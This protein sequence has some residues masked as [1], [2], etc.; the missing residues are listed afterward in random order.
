M[1]KLA[2]SLAF[3]GTCA[4]VLGCGKAL[5]RSGN[6]AASQSTASGTP[7]STRNTTRVGGAE[8]SAD[9]AAIAL[10]MYPGLTTATRPRTVVLADDRDWAGA[11]AASLLAGSPLHA[12]VLYG[13]GSKLPAE[14]ASALRTMRP[15]GAPQL[16]A[17]QV[18]DVGDAL[19]PS[20][21]RARSV[22]AEDPAELA[23]AIERLWSLLV[24]RQPH[25][26]IVTAAD[27]PPA[28]TMPA[29]GLSALTSAPILYVER[30]DIPAATQRELRRLG[31]QTA[32]YVL[33]PSS[34]VSSKVAG[35]L[36]RFGSVTR[37]EGTTAASNAVATARFTDG[38]FGWGVEEPGHGLA[39]AN[40]SRPFDAPAAAPLSASGDYAPL[41]L[42]EAPDSLPSALGRYLDDLQP[43]S[44]PSGPV[45]GV[46]NH[47]WIVGDEAAVSTTTQARLDKILEISSQ[48]ATETTLSTSTASTEEQQTATPPTEEQ[49]T[50]AIEP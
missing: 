48:P 10:T 37:I 12:P 15:R 40:A 34:V 25:Q 28:M 17:T 20:G 3:L 7:G 33:G 44:P 9:A 47:G 39:F 16:G 23:V 19:A 29:A 24:K 1:R 36:E 14:T 35:E 11:L 41:L 38:S 18:I 13:E 2:T 6:H 31:D 8:A 22:G 27:A 43:G 49:Q 26:L 32:I 21:Y 50:S 5:P 30:S 46:Y 45:H 42:L 4:L